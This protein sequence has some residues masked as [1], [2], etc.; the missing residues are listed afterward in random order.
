MRAFP[1]DDYLEFLRRVHDRDLVR[2]ITGVRR[3]GKSTLLELYREELV[4]AGADP[5]SILTINFEDA[6]NDALRSPDAFLVHVLKQVE[7]NSVR[8]LH[9]DEVQELGDWS[10]VIN[11]LRVNPGLEI[12]VT[13]SN[14]TMF[15]GE[16]LTYL[17]GRYIELHMLPLSLAEFRRF[18]KDSGSSAE[19]Y[20]TWMEVGG[21]PAAVLAGDPDITDQINSSLFDSIFTRDIA[22]RGQIRDTEVFLRVARFVFDN[23]GSPLSTN[24]ISN[25]LK[26][27][28]Y[29]SS[30]ES[31]DRYLGLME[32][33]HLI[34]R[35][36]RYDTQ[37]K[38]WLKT[39]GKFYFVDPGLRTALLGSRDVNRGH[40]LENMVYLELRR[41]RYRVS[42]GHSKNAEIDFVAT[43]GMET[44]FIQ[45]AYST[46]DA[47]TLERELR[48]LAAN[49]GRARTYLITADRI[50]PS[51][52][53]VTWI[54]A[55]EF[56]AGA[57]LD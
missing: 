44:A 53:S 31:V 42:T 4:A 15:S 26:S 40:D 49:A 48:P 55:F 3:C 50:P 35:C 20:R 34:Y 57:A 5:R 13:G 16:S 36:S 32:D 28:G 46:D 1:R 24:K 45:V 30:P 25:H 8:Y 12:C 10:R 2:I 37:G 54:D 38:Q 7:V 6:A 17:A 18:R 9:V 29:S 41:R 39:N 11:S 19:A 51:T 27:Q 14:A 33:A 21:F 56:L 43:R 22:T 23:A 47:S 52:G